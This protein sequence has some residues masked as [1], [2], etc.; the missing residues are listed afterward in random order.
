MQADQTIYA[1]Y[2]RKRLHKEMEG[3][4]DKAVIATDDDVHLT[5]TFQ[6]GTIVKITI[7][8]IYPNVDLLGLLDL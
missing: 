2:A 7:P 1:L 3:L 4:A 5:M 6:Q 8:E